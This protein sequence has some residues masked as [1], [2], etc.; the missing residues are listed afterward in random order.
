[1]STCFGRNGA[2]DAHRREGL[3]RADAFARSSRSARTG[4]AGRVVPQADGGLLAVL[5][6]AVDAASDSLW[7]ASTAAPFMADAKPGEAGTALLARIDLAADV[8][9]NRSRTAAAC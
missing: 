5:G 7:V 4:H 6:M 8:S 2:W 1:M 3:V 9:S